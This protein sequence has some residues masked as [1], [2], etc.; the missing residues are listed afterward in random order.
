MA[1]LD[2]SFGEDLAE[3]EFGDYLLFVIIEVE[4]CSGI[5]DVESYAFVAGGG[6]GGCGCG[7]EVGGWDAG[8]GGWVGADEGYGSGD[9]GWFGPLVSDQ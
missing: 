5:G 4:G 1:E 8:V 7:C 2:H 3:V 9:G 6:G